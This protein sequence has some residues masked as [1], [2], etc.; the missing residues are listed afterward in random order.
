MCVRSERVSIVQATPSTYR[1]LLDAGWNSPLPVKALCG[2][3]ALSNDLADKLTTL[4]AELWNVYGPTE[5]TVWATV[6]QIVKGDTITIG[7]PIGNM[8]AY[9]LDE[10]LKPVAIG[11]VGEIYIGGDSVGRGY[12]NRPE[13]T[14]ERFLKNPFD[15]STDGTMYRTGDLGK[16]LE[17]GEIQC[18]GR[19]D[20]QV[21][22]RGHRIEL[23]EIENII[24]TIAEVKQTAVVAHETRSGDQV[25]VAYVVP[26]S[27]SDE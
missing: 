6:K 20:H 8:K 25:L 3:E 5:T 19:I 4:C 11:T 27:V 17:N 18:L 9:I 15:K 23:G 22:I 14:T 1:M 26:E 10:F 16:F 7:R 21:K 2:G 13:L 24:G 12:M